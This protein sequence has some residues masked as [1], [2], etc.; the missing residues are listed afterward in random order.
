MARDSSISLRRASIA[1]AEPLALGV[2]EGVEDYPSFAPAGWTAPLFDV[3]LKHLCEILADPDVCCLVAESDGALIGQITLLPAARAP[4]PSRTRRSRIS[5][6]YL[7]AAITGVPGSLPTSITRP[8]RQ[9]PHEASQSCGSLWPPAKRGRG[10]FTSAR[11]GCRP[12]TLRRPNSRPHDDRIPLQTPRPMNNAPGKRA[13]VLAHQR[14]SLA[15][16]RQRCRCLRNPLSCCRAS[17]LRS[18]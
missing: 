13:P 15:Y 11:T 4:H 6:T 12:A 9:Q 17:A 18:H 5:Q 16:F 14:C 2:I 3:E 7:S 1:D 10:A 8:P